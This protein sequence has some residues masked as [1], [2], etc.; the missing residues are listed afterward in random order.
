MYQVAHE[1]FPTKA[2]VT[3]RCHHIIDTT[4]DYKPVFDRFVPFLTDLFAYLDDWQERSAM[5]RHIFV[6]TTYQGARCFA[7]K[8]RTGCSTEISHKKAI[9]LMLPVQEIPLTKSFPIDYQLAAKASIASQI[10]VFQQ[11]QF[12]ACAR[13]P[14]RG[15][16]LTVKNSKIEYLPLWTFD[17]LLFR[18]TME[19]KID[20]FEAVERPRFDKSQIQLAGNIVTQWRELH[21]KL[22]RLRIVSEFEARSSM[23]SEPLPKAEPVWTVL[24]NLAR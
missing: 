1:Q 7:V 19:N 16:L 18:F 9:S 14:E 20:P 15:V 10:D 12:L 23:A 2:E 13:C 21:R 24:L 4:E 6:H 11:K 17:N 8:N 3:R 22:A 5:M